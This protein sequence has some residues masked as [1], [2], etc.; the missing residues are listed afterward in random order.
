MSHR[1]GI[2]TWTNI[3]QW[4]FWVTP[5]F[6]RAMYIFVASGSELWLSWRLHIHSRYA[7]RILAWICI[8]FYFGAN[9]EVQR[10][11][12]PRAKSSFIMEICYWRDWLSDDTS[13]K[14][15]NA[16]VNILYTFTF[17]VLIG[18]LLRGNTFHLLFLQF[19]KFF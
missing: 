4:L 15:F 7:C 12:I 9:S 13:N 17:N 3:T 5:N 18:R 16:T 6:F 2:K 10:T 1:N 11:G 8:L 19:Y 14:K